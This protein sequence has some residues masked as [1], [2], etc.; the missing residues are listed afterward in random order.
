MN[1][2][3]IIKGARENNLKNIDVEIPKNKLV[4]IT[5]L[6]GSGKSSLAFDT[7]YAEGQRRYLESLSSYARQF[8]GGNEKPDVD[9]IEGLS[10]SISI[11]Q[12]S[13]S[14]NPRS[15]VG[16][17]TEIYDYL[18][19]LFARIGSPYCPNG[20][21]LIETLTTKQILG[22]ITETFKDGDHLQILSPLVYKQKG[23]FKTELDKLKTE[24]FLRIRVDD[25]NYSLDEKIEIEKN[26]FHNID[27]I[28]DRIIAHNDSETRSRINDALETALKYGNGKVV[29]IDEDK[30][31]VY[32]QSHSCKICGFTIPEMEPRLFSFN[33]PVGACPHCKGL[34]FTYEPDENKMIP[35]KSL[36]I[37]MGGIDYFK[38]TVNTTSI[39]WQRFNI[40]LEHYKID[41]NKPLGKLTKKEIDLMMYGSDEPLN[42]ELRSSGGNSY[43]KYDYVEGIMELVRRRHLETSSEMARQYYSKY[44]SEKTCEACHGKKL[45]PAA[46]SVKIGGK[47]IIE[48]TE[49]SIRECI[50]FL[51]KLELSE[52]QQLI[53]KLALKEIV[54]RLTFLDNV[55]LNYLTLSRSAAT[56][57][58][59]EAQ[60]IRLATQIGSH[61]TGVLYVLD[62]PSIGLHQKDNS[63]LIKTLKKMRDLGNTLI[64]VEHDEETM[65]S[66]DY[67]IDVGPG[68]GEAGGKIVAVGTPGEVM[69]NSKSLT[70]KYLSGE[71]S[72]PIP[73]A[74][75]SG[76]GQKI[77]L[78]GANQNNL[79][80]LE[81]VFPLGKLIV[82]TGVSGSGK[83]T[84]VNETLAKNIQKQLFSPFISAPPIKSLVGINGIDKLIL[85]TQDP[86]G[87]T[88][89]SNPATYVGVFD[90]IR[91]LFALLPESRARGYTKGR[92]SFNVPGGR[93]EKCWGDGVIKIEMHFLPDVY[94]KCTECNGKKYN[95]ETLSIKYKGK[96]IYDILEMNVAEALEFFK[97][98][99]NIRH[100]LE[101]MNDVGLGYIKLGTAATDLSGG[102]AQRVKL[103]KFLQ[104]RASNNT[105]V[106]LDEPT[107]GLHTHDIKNLI[108]VLNRI[109]D[110]GATVIV[111]EHNM[112]LIKSADYIIDLGPDGGD[113]GGNVIATGTPEQVVSKINVSYTAEYLKKALTKKHN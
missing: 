1:D 88:P 12:K 55:G 26:K 97:N 54:D 106:I 64:V 49:L 71:L 98:I 112:D 22:K 107:T 102:E 18:R 109:V 104:K 85:V 14:H 6:S 84:L 86:I 59:G 40:M 101:L 75:R 29:I 105:I 111:I 23:T 21:G 24:G 5:G 72:I 73:K 38:N 39:D 35:D 4:V 57:S 62:E 103:A 66:S 15:T 108:T 51:L 52:Q 93:C 65:L 96:S 76:N 33:N 63:K 90:D 28:I 70:G 30:E 43:S 25:N 32:S 31:G 45:S 61:L 2:Q 83:S 74:R 78:K 69:K 42:I 77:I 56:L 53:A 41:K 100:K 13:T 91:D 60:R 110:S 8:L 80:N 113:Q 95:D 20:H 9:V 7:I 34:G 81:V 92:F 3:L 50:D 44:M 11:D 82:V 87:R 37:N 58:G 47:D 89:R 27:I 67:L 99:P 36:S 94:V 16:T 46:L 48:V 10:P 17:V 79:K 68:A 19:V